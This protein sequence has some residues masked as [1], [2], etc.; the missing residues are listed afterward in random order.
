MSLGSGTRACLHFGGPTALLV[1]LTFAV[2]ACQSA[3]CGEGLYADRG[4]CFELKCGPCGPHQFCDKSEPPPVCRCAPGY[5]GDPCTFEGLILDPS[6]RQEV[7]TGAWVNEGGKGAFVATDEPGDRDLGVG[8]L[9]TSVVCNAGSLLQ[10]V[11]IPTYEVAE[12]FVAE[13]EYRTEVVDEAEGEL[14]LAI[15]FNR[16]WQQLPPSSGWTTQSFCLG[17][18]A[19]GEEAGGSPVDVRI[20]ASKPLRSCTSAAPEI[21]VG[22]FDI[23]PDTEGKCPAPGSVVNGTADD[24][25]APW[26]WFAEDD[27]SAGIVSGAG[28]TKSDG[29]RL[30]LAADAAGRAAIS[31]QISVPLPTSMRSP[32]LR[33]WWRGTTQRLFE[34]KLGKFKFAGL[35]ER[36]RQVD[37]LVGTIDTEVNDNLGVERTYCLPP[38]THGSVFDLSFSLLEGQS[39][40]NVEFVVDNVAIVDA[41][42]CESVDGLLDPGFDAG[43]K[44]WFGVS[45]G[46]PSEHVVMQDDDGN[47]VL[48]LAYWTTSADLSIERYVLV[49]AAEGAEGPAVFFDSRSPEPLSLDVRATAA[50]SAVSVDVEAQADWE[51]NV[52]CLPRQW[53]GRWFPFEVRVEPEAEQGDSIETERVLL[54]DFSLGPSPRCVDD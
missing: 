28:E 36:G 14:E 54:D 44:R 4:E 25:G 51:Q 17:E 16:S 9:R 38:W 35:D 31:T 40:E 11:Q 19:Y 48:E 50:G 41:D 42:D 24:D 10:T 3:Q 18:G 49:P 1:V 47:G 7:D 2:G 21:K 5:A 46:S 20:S 37:T 15:G 45:L 30:S 12:A 32:A 43:A 22:Y 8:V 53:V 33:F 29:A 26:T 23:G 6:F 27:A 34:V 39:S 52:V 13:V